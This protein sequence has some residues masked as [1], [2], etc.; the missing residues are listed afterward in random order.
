ML[1]RVGEWVT[2]LDLTAIVPLPVWAL[3]VG[4]ALVVLVCLLALLRA[5]ADGRY[6]PSFVLVLVL[7]LAGGLWAGEYLAR[8][9]LAAELRAVETRAFELATRAF[10]PGSALGCLDPIAGETVESACE[11]AL[12]ASP[13]ATAAAVSYVAAQL[14]LLA[15]AGELGRRHGGANAGAARLRHALEADR[16][17]IVAHVLA[18]RDGCTPDRCSAFAWLRD[19]S[20]IKLNLAQQPFET[21]LKSLAASWPAAASGGVASRAPPPAPTAAAKPPN[22]LYF[23]SASSIPPVNIMTA[24]PPSAQRPPQDPAGTA[25]AAPP[26]PLRRPPQADLPARQSPS[27]APARPAPMPLAPTQ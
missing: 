13:E 18:I 27:A 17:G 26:T 8:R 11:K 1:D 15:S 20:Q 12:F 10:A 4:T 6:L 14:T 7:V 5:G 24:E 23:P 2:A 16:F 22:N 3:A 19:A 9:E 25:E 21:R